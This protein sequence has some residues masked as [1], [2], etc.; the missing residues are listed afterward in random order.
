MHSYMTCTDNFQHMTL[1]LLEP[2]HRNPKTTSS[3]LSYNAIASTVIGLYEHK[4]YE[5]NWTNH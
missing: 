1:G 2:L 4:L 5:K 3:Q